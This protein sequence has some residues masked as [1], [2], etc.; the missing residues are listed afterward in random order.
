MDCFVDF[1]AVFFGDELVG[2]DEPAEFVGIGCTLNMLFKC[3]FLL[4]R[5]FEEDA[6]GL[7][8]GVAGII[9]LFLGDDTG[10]CAAAAATTAAAAHLITPF[11]NRLM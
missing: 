5:H 2:V 8:Q 1:H 11:L 10:C 4:A 3:V 9:G 7:F 6:G